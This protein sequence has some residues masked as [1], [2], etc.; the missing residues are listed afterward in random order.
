VHPGLGWM[1]DLRFLGAVAGHPSL[2]SDSRGGRGGA[3]VL[4][5]ACRADDTS[6]AEDP[7]NGSARRG[8]EPRRGRLSA[9]ASM[10]RYGA[11][12]GMPEEVLLFDPA[13]PGGSPGEPAGNMGY[14]A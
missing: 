4:A 14:P 2:K 5:P 10:A 1:P 7:G 3:Q 13:Y 8:A 12:T 11:A 6:A 9:I